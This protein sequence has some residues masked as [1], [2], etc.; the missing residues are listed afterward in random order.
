MCCL[1]RFRYL[2]QG[3]QSDK[4]SDNPVIESFDVPLT[5]AP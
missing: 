1:Y 5:P 4:Q 3:K 2:K